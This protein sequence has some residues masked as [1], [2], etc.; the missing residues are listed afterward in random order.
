MS[1]D[2]VAR[3][4]VAESWSPATRYALVTSTLRVTGRG[5]SATGSNR[6]GWRVEERPA[7]LAR[8]EKVAAELVRG[9]ASGDLAVDEARDCLAE[10]GFASAIRFAAT[11]DELAAQLT[12]V[13]RVGDNVWVDCSPVRGGV[14]YQRWWADPSHPRVA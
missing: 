9:L 12:E 10:S 11:A 8:L 7:V 3:R 13:L 6:G 5:Q 2:E 1:A 14:I 4:C